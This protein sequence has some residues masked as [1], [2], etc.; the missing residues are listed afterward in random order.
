MVI[1]PVRLRIAPPPPSP[2]NSPP[3][4]LM[5]PAV[6]WAVLPTNVLW[7]M[8]TDGGSVGPVVVGPRSDVI[9]PPTPMTNP[10]DV[11]S[12]KRLYETVRAPPNSLATAP[13]AV[14][15][16]A[17]WLPTMRTRSR[18]TVPPRLYSPPPNEKPGFEAAVG[19]NP[20]ALVARPS[21]TVSSAI[22]TSGDV[23]TWAAVG[24]TNGLP[25]SEA[26]STANTRVAPPLTVS[27]WAPGPLM[28][29]SSV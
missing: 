28:A 21:A 5:C 1:D 23:A 13:P 27:L 12:S 4:A 7:S 2:V 10:A 15:T 9:A 22:A 25:A 18:W 3:G 24:V 6:A 8:L 17:A 26:G 11:L 16:P 19:S 14:T 20:R 29:T